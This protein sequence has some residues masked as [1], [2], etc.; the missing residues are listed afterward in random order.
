VAD[1]KYVRLIR[2]Y[3]VLLGAAGVRRTLLLDQIDAAARDVKLVED[4]LAQAK[5]QEEAVKQDVAAAKEEVKKYA[6]ERNAVKTYRTTL[7][8]E[9]GA[10]KAGIDDL[11]KNNQKMAQQ[12]AKLQWEAVRRIDQRTR[13]MAR[14]GAGGT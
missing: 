7:E 14:S 1:G 8:Q 11:L 2:D 13:A 12:I 3:H 10:T 5:Q 6:A 9:L 4:A